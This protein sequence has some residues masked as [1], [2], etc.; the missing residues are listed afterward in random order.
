MFLKKIGE[1]KR[2]VKRHR[3]KDVKT[4]RLRKSKTN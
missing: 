1:K 2:N 3:M 4:D